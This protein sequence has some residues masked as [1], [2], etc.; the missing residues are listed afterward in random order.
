MGS[1]TYQ[2]IPGSMWEYR[3]S[4][5]LLEEFSF[6]RKKEGRDVLKDEDKLLEKE[7]RFDI[8]L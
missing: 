8:T 7:F 3:N 2:I 5:M 4:L 1:K 6:G